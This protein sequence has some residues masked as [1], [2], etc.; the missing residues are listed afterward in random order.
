M[1][2]TAK[3]KKRNK[4]IIIRSIKLILI[5]YCIIGFLFYYFQ[6]KL[7]L[8]PKPLTQG[9][10]FKFNS[11]FTEVN[12]PLNADEILNVIEFYGKDPV[13]KGVVIYFHGN[14]E[15]VTHYASAAEMFIKKGY[16]VWMPDYPGFGKTTG[17]IS[18]Q[19][20]YDQSLIVYKLA[21]KK[22]NTGSIIIYGRSFG[23]GIAAHLASY[24]PNKRL[25][26]ETP[27]FS[28]PDL[29]SSY[30]PIYPMESMSAFK[31]NTYKFLQD[32]KVPVT[33]FH[34]DADRVIPYKCAKKLKPYL[35]TG[36]EFITIE[37]GGHNNL[38][39]F[40]LFREKLDSLLK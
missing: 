25:I 31:M 22:Y 32:V 21:R 30:V 37:K 12:I 29:F 8:H 6:E 27:Y 14:A 10:Q 7:L 11:P 2:V 19:K 28:I 34:G 38:S 17:K 3:R 13:K 5:L 18:E 23:S 35:K 40:P 24:I 15:N 36:D 39:T 9:Y 20:L 16:E 1:T 33:I 4:K 26:L